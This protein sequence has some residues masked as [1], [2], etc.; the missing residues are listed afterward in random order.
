MQSRF[1]ESQ[2]VAILKEGRSRRTT[3]R[4]DDEAWGQSCDP[5]AATVPTSVRV[6]SGTNRTQVSLAVAL[7]PA[8]AQPSRQRYPGRQPTIVVCVFLLSSRRGKPTEQYD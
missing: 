3:Q 6:R 1:T 2:I 7:P 8:V 4:A 5:G